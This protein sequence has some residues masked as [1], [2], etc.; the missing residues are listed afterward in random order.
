TLLGNVVFDRIGCGRI[1]R[2]SS[3]RHARVG[4]LVLGTSV[5]RMG[6]DSGVA[7]RYSRNLWRA[8]DLERSLDVCRPVRS[9]GP[10][11]SPKTLDLAHSAVWLNPLAR[12][13]RA[14]ESGD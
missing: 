1:D 9:A 4:R 11:F 5:N 3:D 12:P 10:P 8:R 13:W 2:R 6:G 14:P 7:T